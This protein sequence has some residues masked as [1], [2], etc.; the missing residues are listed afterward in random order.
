[1]AKNVL[2]RNVPDSVHAALIRR[3][4]IEGKSLQEYL[5]GV[6]HEI[7]ERPTLAEVMDTVRERL[8][9]HEGP[10]PTRDEIVATLRS[11]RDA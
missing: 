11:L 5:Q 3:A 9:N 10:A 2:V 7:T 4:D 8:A 1:M 6:L